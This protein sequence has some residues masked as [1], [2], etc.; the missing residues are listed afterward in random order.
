MDFIDV[1]LPLLNYT[2]HDAGTARSVSRV[3]AIG[4]RSIH[5]GSG[6]GAAFPHV[7]LELLL[8]ALQ[9]P[10]AVPAAHVF[11]FPGWKT[12]LEIHEAEDHSA[13]VS[14]VADTAVTRAERCQ[15]LDTAVN[16]HEIL[17]FDG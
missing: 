1:P 2:R 8:G 3:C 12:H 5:P 4:V 13:E 16:H 7:N 15:Q 11:H 9:L 6:A 17:R 10:V 14:D